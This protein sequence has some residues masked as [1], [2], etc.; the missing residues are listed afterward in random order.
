MTS[1]P[2][3]VQIYSRFQRIVLEE[4]AEEGAWTLAL[5]RTSPTSDRHPI[6]FWFKAGELKH[7]ADVLDAA[8]ILR[9]AGR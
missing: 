2:I 1:P 7:L 4:D 8:E 9:K 3:K 5:T 6:I